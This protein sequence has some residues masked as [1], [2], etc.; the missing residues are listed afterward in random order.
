MNRWLCLVPALALLALPCPAPACSLCGALANRATFRYESEQSKLVL[1]G[2]LANP[3]FNKDP[4]APP[5][6]G[7]TDFH[8]ERILKDDPLRG[9]RNTIELPRYQPV[10]DPKNPPR[11]V[12]F[13]NAVEGKL[14]VYGGRFV[15]SEAVLKYLEGAMA[16]AGKDRV[17][18]LQYFFRFL[19]HEDASVS[20]DAFLEFARSSDEEVGKVAVKLP[21]DQIRRLLQNPKTPPERL[22]LYA[23]LL[24]ATGG[25]QDA[26]LLRK[27]IESPTERTTGA[28]D[29]LLAGYIHMRPKEGWDL[30]VSMLGDSRRGFA[31]RFAVA[32]ALRFYHGWKPAET[33]QQILRGLDAMVGDGDVADVAIEDLRKWKMWDL[34]G[35]VLAQFGK[36]SHDTPIARRTIV[37]YALSCP[38]PEARRFVDE[39]RRRDPDLVRELEEGLEL[40]KQ[41]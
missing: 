32:R 5:G 31:Q 23:F 6:S 7:Q 38:Q 39:L 36:P 26:A 12:I 14:N 19:D 11:F 27:M 28:L 10:L 41:G 30:L 9:G 1:V 8:V 33:R 3:R 35:K 40:E 18:A 16:Q 34:T 2:T 29:G 22:G 37:R 20:M 24:G 4:S 21:A 13:C 25:E 17:Q 15:P